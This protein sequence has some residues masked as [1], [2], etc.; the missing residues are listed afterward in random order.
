MHPSEIAQNLQ[1]IKQLIAA[2]A[3]K[4]GR[5]PDDIKLIAVSKGRSWP[6]VEAAFAAGQLRFGENTVQDAMS[7]ISRCV[8]PAIE[9]H[10]IGHLQSNKAKYIPSNFAWLHSLDSVALATKLSRLARQK[11]TPL[12]VLIE[13]NITGEVNK[14]GIAPSSLI[15]FIEELLQAQLAGLELR[16]LMAIGPPLANERA[17]RAAFSKLRELRDACA[18]RFGLTGF[19]ALSM[20]MSG[21]FVPAIMEG[22]TLVRIGTAI[23][24]ERRKP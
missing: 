22:A 18:P 14:H 16:G 3:A 21:D 10:F 4:S 23:F 2:A 20:G 24:G 12:K 7:K 17:L 5:H 11:P 6:Q 9:W 15:H 19:T 1:R 13:V 8:H